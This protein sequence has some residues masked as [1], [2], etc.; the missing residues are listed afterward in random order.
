MEEVGA[1]AELGGLA[2]DGVAD[3]GDVA[4]A[5]LAEALRLGAGGVALRLGGRALLGRA[6]LGR[7]RG[8]ELLV[9]LVQHALAP[10]HAR[11]LVRR[12]RLRRRQR[13]QLV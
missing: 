3:G 4:R 6:L 2:E 5:G 9:Q 12:A 13:S 8:P 10:L 11:L 7:A 1:G